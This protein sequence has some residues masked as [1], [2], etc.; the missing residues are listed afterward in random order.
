ME[1]LTRGVAEIISPEDLTQK[2][3]NSKKTGIPL[4]I[5][6]GIDPTAPHV[7]LGFAVVLRKLR[8]F[9]DMGHRVQLLIGDFTARVGDPTGKSETRKMLTPEEIEQNAKTYREQLGIILDLDRTDVV[10]NST[11]LMPLNFADIINLTSKYTVARIMERDDFSNRF[12]AGKPLGMHE[13]LYPLM[14][15]YDSVALKSDVEMGGTDQKFNI[16]VGRD[17]QR[18]FGQEPQV[19]ML[20]PILEGTDGV[21]KMSKSYG[22]YIG[23]TE[24]PNEM[25]GHVMSIPDNLITRYFELCTDVPM[26]EVEKAK[27]DMENNRVNPRDWKIR[28]AY[29]IVSIYHNKEKA[30]EAEDEFKRVFSKK[31]MPSE[32]DEIKIP[33]ELTSDGNINIADLIIAANMAPS[34][35]EA[36]RLI[37]QGAV[38]LDVVKIE[39]PA[40]Q[41]DLKTEKILQVG[42]RK[43]A[44]VVT[45]W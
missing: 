32:I 43:F 8:K 22:N 4:K 10:F 37:Q 19:V 36:R 25:F 7:H 9:Q 23:I 42:S 16:L 2:L 26:N 1:I 18:E 6:L 29:E 15:G 3:I 38:K 27:E 40:E 33:K 35:R 21:L 14:Q 34:K 41:I 31:E 24:P 30:K 17:L 5:K 13:I 11:W 28:L 45:D 20:M 12:K 44:R 39:N